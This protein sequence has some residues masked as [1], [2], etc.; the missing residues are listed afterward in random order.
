MSADDF[1]TALNALLRL[2]R[3]AGLDEY[4]LH[5]EMALA[6]MQ[7]HDDHHADLCETED[8]DAFADRD[9]A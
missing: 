9:S 7:L 8:D 1:K 4:F 3:H 6:G 5:S 2:A